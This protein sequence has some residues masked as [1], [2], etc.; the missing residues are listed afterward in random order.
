M[1]TVVYVANQHSRAIQLQEQ[2]YAADVITMIHPLEEHEATGYEVLV[3][4]AE[5]EDALR[6]II[7]MD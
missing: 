2:L 3:P 4:Q 7:D 6:L 1:W 5:L